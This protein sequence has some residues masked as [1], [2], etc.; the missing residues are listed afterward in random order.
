VAKF[1][2]L[3]LRASALCA[4]LLSG[5]VFAADAPED[6]AHDQ[7]R[8]LR[9]EMVAAFEARDIDALLAHVDPEVVVTFQNGEVVRGPEA[10]R[11]FF[12]RMMIG[13][14]SIVK[15]MKTK[16]DV[17]TLSILHGGDT[18]ISYGTL[19]DHWVLRGGIDMDLVSH[20]TATLLRGDGGWRVGAFHVSAS[21]FDNPLLAE[22][23]AGLWKAAA[24]AGVAGLALGFAGASLRK[25]A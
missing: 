5:R 17:S 2:T 3:V 22:A 25:R 16:L 1:V 14:Q 12:Q 20:W 24:L 6:P 18:A 4:L 21:L 13:E 10:L 8:K 11:G 23:K 7:L 19:N 9:D 15:E